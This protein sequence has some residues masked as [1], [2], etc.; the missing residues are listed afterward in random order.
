MLVID[1]I[2]FYFHIN[3]K[4]SVLLKN[5]ARDAHPVDFTA[6]ASED[7]EHIVGEHEE[8][9]IV[10]QYCQN[11][12]TSLDQEFG[13]LTTL[14]TKEQRNIYKVNYFKDGEES[15]QARASSRDF[16]GF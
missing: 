3:K 2:N 5:Y 14:Y 1:L 9:N 13:N 15:D 12:M 8:G 6:A 4:S 16:S 11:I 10:K 7:S